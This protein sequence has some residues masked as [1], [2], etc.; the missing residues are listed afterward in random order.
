MT[1]I[2]DENVTRNDITP[3]IRPHRFQQPPVKAK[4]VG[5]PVDPNT[6]SVRTENN[7]NESGALSQE[8][9]PPA[10]IEPHIYL[11][12]SHTPL[13]IKCSD[14]APS[15]SELDVATRALYKRTSSPVTFDPVTQGPCDSLVSK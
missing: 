7:S 9:T 11:S 2:V 12:I 6:P 1:Y 5:Q 8:G 15:V 4:W 10:L 13:D 3:L 14:S